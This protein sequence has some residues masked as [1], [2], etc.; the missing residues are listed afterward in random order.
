MANGG[1]D[2]K[3]I[4]HSLVQRSLVEAVSG[5]ECSPFHGRVVAG[6]A[7]PKGFADSRG[8]YAGL[9]PPHG[10]TG[11]SSGKGQREQ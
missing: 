4:H 5:S 9:A 10:F 6:M 11:P 3:T 7:T 1:F 2:G 8:A